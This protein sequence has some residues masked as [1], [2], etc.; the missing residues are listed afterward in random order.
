[1]K[2]FR[3]SNIPTEF[4]EADLKLLLGGCPDVDSLAP[5]ANAIDAPR[6]QVALV[7]FETIPEGFETLRSIK[8]PK[9]MLRKAKIEGRRGDLKVDCDFL[10]LTPLNRESGEI[11]M[12][13]VAV[14]GGHA[15]GA[16]KAKSA[17]FMWLRDAL[18]EDI[19]GLRVLTYGF[20]AKLVG[21]TSFAGIASY[22][23]ELLEELKGTRDHYAASLFFSVLFPGTM[24]L[25]GAT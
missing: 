10:G 19:T 7:S 20:N 11:V 18:P 14:A 6:K 12:D 5:A 8:I 23:T 22:A 21:S 2:T 9:E 13:V 4:T 15:F 1:M 24:R 16:W 17:D 3:I 25:K